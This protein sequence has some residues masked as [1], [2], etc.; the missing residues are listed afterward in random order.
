MWD[1][2]EGSITDKAGADWTSI[3]PNRVVNADRWLMIN[4]W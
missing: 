2:N 4:I 3:A 1:H